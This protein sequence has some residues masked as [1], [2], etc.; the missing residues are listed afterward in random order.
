M[1][2]TSLSPQLPQTQKAWRVV[3]RGAPQEALEFNQAAP[4][5][6]PSDL[7]PGEIILKVQ[8][9]ALNPV[10]YKMMK[11]FPNFIAR[12]PYAAAEHDLA[13]VV[14]A[15]H[16]SV[17]SV[18]E[19]DE[20]FGYID[21][22]LQ[23][24]S[25]QGALAQYTR[26]PAARVT[27][28]SPDVPPTGA[29]GLT[30]AGVTAL[31][32]LKAAGLAEGMT[33]FVNGGSSSVGAFAIQI[34]KAKGCTVWASASRKN[35][36]FVRSL[37]ADEVL[38]YT[39][40]PLETQ[41]ASHPHLPPSKF[42]VLYDAVALVD[43]TLYKQGH[44]YIAR[45]GVYVTTGPQPHGSSQ[46]IQIFGTL[47]AALLP[48]WLGGAQN[49]YHLVRLAPV[50]EDI[51]ELGELVRQGKVKPVVDSVFAFEDVLKAYERLLTNRAK[52]KVV[53]KVDRT[54]E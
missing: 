47:R 36:E 45:N 50:E 38:D 32:G 29:A 14:V 26:L 15:T 33:V 2:S 49:S 51:K 22:A 46:W 24:K 43:P 40:A 9:A 19:G 27:L 44:A 41:L 35:H 18:K 6:S 12:R 16:P 48:T 11:L 54:V 7:K 28:R 3:R 21:V 30:L 53:V 42:H 23:I 25:S 4:V 31:Q 34:A 8:A 13:G 20:V 1:S 17:T 52:G 37:G 5:P 10:G 39:E